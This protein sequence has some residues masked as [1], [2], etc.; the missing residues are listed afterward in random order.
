MKNLLAL[1]IALTVAAAAQDK[2][3][4]LIAPGGIRAAI[5][6]MI[7][8]F[9]KKSGY[10]VKATFGSGLGTKKQVAEGGAFD[11]P[12]V[13]CDTREQAIAIAKA[14]QESTEAM[15]AK[16][17]QLTTTINDKGHPS[18]ANSRISYLV[19]NER[20]DFGL[21]HAANGDLMHIWVVH[22]A[23][24]RGEFWFIYAQS[25]PQTIA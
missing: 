20:E 1:T 3:I 24:S 14:G 9:E 2:E 18:C 17:E 6:Q 5:V 12:V 4:T 23:A 25:D 19:V 16:Y 7:P 22:G 13:T 10:K 8:A 15:L 11:V 21:A